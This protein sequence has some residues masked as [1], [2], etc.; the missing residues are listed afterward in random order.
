MNHVLRNDS[1][2]FEGFKHLQKVCKVSVR[3][4]IAVLLLLHVENITFT[5]RLFIC[6]VGSR[7]FRM[8]H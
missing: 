6:K 7:W 4:G 8:V 5:S 3:T 1:H 2:Y